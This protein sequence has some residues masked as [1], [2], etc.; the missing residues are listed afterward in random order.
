[1]DRDAASARADDRALP[2][3]TRRLRLLCAA[4]LALLYIAGF[5]R[6]N[7]GLGVFG[8]AQPVWHENFDQAWYWRSAEAF[9]RGDLSASEHWYPP[10][11]SLIMAPFAWLGEARAQLVVG[12][13]LYLAA[14]AA[15]AAIARHFAVSRL[16]AALLFGLATFWLDG[17]ARAWTWPWTT[18]LSGVLILSGIA[19]TLRICIDGPEATT[20][21][22]TSNR[23]TL[24]LLGAIL[25]AIPCARPVDGIVSA[26][27]GLFA[28]WQCLVVRRRPAE[29][30]AI[31]AGS[32]AVLLPYAALY[33]AIWG[34]LASPYARM[35]SA[36]GF[37]FGQ[38]G[39][40]AYVL[41]VE[42]QPWY[43]DS[44]AI[45]D[46][47][48]WLMLGGA[49]MI[50][51]LINPRTRKVMAIIA[52]PLL[53]YSVLMLCYRAIVPSG[54]WLYGLMHYF[55]WVILVGLLLTIHFF[56]Q[57][58]A[59][60]KPA[61]VSVLALLVLTGISV[62][63]VP[64][65]PGE[66][67]RML[68][69]SQRLPLANQLVYMGETSVVDRRGRQRNFFEVQAIPNHDGTIKVLALARDFA[70]DEQISADRPWPGQVRAAKAVRVDGFTSAAIFGPLIGRYRPAVRFG[71]PCWL[72]AYSCPARELPAPPAR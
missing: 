45:L 10:L 33:L 27:L 67:A 40:K 66:P 44:V 24:L 16:P 8:G 64:A 9:W 14:F 42:P 32:I 2:A 26:A 47:M 4:A 58:K 48:P 36:G 72:P 25:A 38:L 18:S 6:A 21:A 71:L 11:Y 35:A 3:E 31:I 56:Q 57:Y 5:L 23:R 69:F 43:P 70:G 37:E 7:G 61:V 13:G 17:M 12:L 62:Q 30:I 54:L 20:P 34:P 59:A 19:L 28:G 46:R 55:K 15:F 22:S 60:P 49:G 52:L 53:A 65:Q 39:W 50:A 63:A 68:V 41:L 51:G 29:L 1:M